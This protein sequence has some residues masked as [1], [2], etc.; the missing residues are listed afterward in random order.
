M[1]FNGTLGRKLPVSRAFFYIS[2]GFRNN[3]GL[4]IKQNLTFLL[5]FQVKPPPPP[6]SYPTRS[7][8]TEM[9]ISRAYYYIFFRVPIKEHFLQVPLAG[10]P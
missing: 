4:Q 9:S 7:V 10:L 8:W 3:Q 2:L 5:K 6:H 1:F